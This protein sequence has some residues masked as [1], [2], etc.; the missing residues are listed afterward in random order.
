MTVLVDINV[1]LDVFQNR[2]PHYVDSAIVVDSITRGSLSGVC[3]SHGIAT[4]YYMMEKH[5]TSADAAAAVDTILKH[6]DVIGLHKA[7]WLAARS[8]NIT[9]LEDAAVA[10]AALLAG[11]AFILT[12]NVR[13]FANSSVPAMTPSDF[14]HRFLPPP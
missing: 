1:L 7:D 10:Q 8:L 6:F 4:L 2:Q 11:A 14:I 9:D 3:P 13:D 12:R 5:G